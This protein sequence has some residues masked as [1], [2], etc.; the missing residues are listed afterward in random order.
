VL[1]P[2]PH[3][4]GWLCG[5]AHIVSIVLRIVADHDDDSR[6]RRYSRLL[7]D[8]FDDAAPDALKFASTIGRSARRRPSPTRAHFLRRVTEK[9]NGNS[10]RKLATISAVVK[11]NAKWAMRLQDRIQDEDGQW[12]AGHF[13][14]YSTCRTCGTDHKLVKGCAPEMRLVPISRPRS[15]RAKVSEG[16]ASL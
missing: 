2:P 5:T 4:R 13:A 9:S 3:C 10:K 6:V 16:F 15:L 1:R 7:R 11:W 12:S 8:E 14:P